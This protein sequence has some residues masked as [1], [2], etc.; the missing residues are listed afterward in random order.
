MNVASLNLCKELYEISGWGRGD[1]L[2]EHLV[3]DEEGYEYAVF[4]A[5]DLGYLLRKLPPNFSTGDARGSFEFFLKMTTREWFAGYNKP[6]TGKWLYDS[7]HGVWEHPCAAHTP[8]DAAAK[9][10]IELFKQEILHK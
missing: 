2:Q 4:P 3:V 5:Y 8:E 7:N 6:E 1:Q 10:A 9:L